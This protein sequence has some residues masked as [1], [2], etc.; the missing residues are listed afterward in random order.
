[1][2]WGPHRAISRDRKPRRVLKRPTSH[3]PG[4]VHRFGWTGAGCWVGNELR[5]RMVREGMRRS[6]PVMLCGRL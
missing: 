3:L 5:A 4:W 1:M 2:G 6:L